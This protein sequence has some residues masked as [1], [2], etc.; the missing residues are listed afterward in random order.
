MD[1]ICKLYYNNKKFNFLFYTPSDSFNSTSY[2]N[3]FAVGTEKFYL[4]FRQNLLHISTTHLP[5][6]HGNIFVQSTPVLPSSKGEQIRT[7]E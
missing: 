6:P 2:F 5:H 1:L 7:K 3:F 4:I